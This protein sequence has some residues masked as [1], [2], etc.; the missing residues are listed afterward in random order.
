VNIW[1]KFRPSSSK[2]TPLLSNQG[3]RLL[4]ESGTSVVHVSNPF[5]SYAHLQTFRPNPLNC[6]LNDHLRHLR[7]H[8]LPPMLPMPVLI[9][10][11]P[12]LPSL[13]YRIVPSL[14][15]STPW[16]SSSTYHARWFLILLV[17]R[18]Y[19]GLLA[20]VGTAIFLVI[21]LL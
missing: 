20:L 3:L 14:P 13:L 18:T 16:T 9:T 15:I 21:D 2:S 1:I 12:S 5:K 19:L 6:H 10:M 11:N 7:P 17:R 4:S 8:R